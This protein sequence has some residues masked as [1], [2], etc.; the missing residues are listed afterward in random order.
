MTLNILVPI[1]GTPVA[2]QAVHTAIHLARQGLKCHVLL[3]NVQAP[4]TFY[5][6]INE[7]NPQVLENVAEGAGQHTL[8]QAKALL[9]EAEIPHA[10]EVV[11]GDPAHAL[12]DLVDTRQIGMI[13][14]GAHG[15]GWLRTALQGSVSQTL[16]QD[17]AV[18]VLVVKLPAA[19]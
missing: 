14:I 6:I 16:L 5:E 13:V 17:A 9:G 10:S 15:K 4:A 7:P 2:L 3:A 1:D 12:L 19:D 8:A 11:T 18:P